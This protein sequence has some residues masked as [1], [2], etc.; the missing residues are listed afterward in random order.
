M[1]RRVQEPSRHVLEASRVDCRVEALEFARWSCRLL[2][3]LV[4]L[5]LLVG[6]R[7]MLSPLVPWADNAS[8]RV[9]LVLIVVLLLL[10]V[11]FLR[12]VSRVADLAFDLGF[13]AHALRKGIAVKF[14]NLQL[15][16]VEIVRVG[17]WLFILELI[18]VSSIVQSVQSLVL[19]VA[20][21]PGIVRLLKH[22]WT[23]AVLAADDRV[24]L[25]RNVK[26]LLGFLLQNNSA[27]NQTYLGS[28]LLF[29]GWLLGLFWFRED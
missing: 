15:G 13:Q 16:G 12:L 1:F 21:Q 26:H 7:F 6:P 22:T 2:L 25:R 9:L 3:A 20:L 24:I 14:V 5:L 4:L 10:L 23:L 17:S 8:K 19:R 11:A 28:L 29:G 18:V 27:F